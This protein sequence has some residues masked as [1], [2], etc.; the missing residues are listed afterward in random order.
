ME[1]APRLIILGLRFADAANLTQAFIL[2]TSNSRKDIKFPR[3]TAQTHIRTNI[4][5]RNYSTQKPLLSKAPTPRTPASKANALPKKPVKAVAAKPVVKYAPSQT[6]KPTAQRAAPEH[7]LVYHAGTGKIV[8]LGMLRTAT[9]FVAGAS[10]IIIAPAF[11]ADEFPSYLAPLIVIGGMLPLIFVAYTTAPFV[12]NIYLHLPVF[13]RKSREAA[14]EYVK[15]LPSTATLSIKT[16]KITTIPRTTEVRISDLVRDKS[17][18]RP[19]TFRN[20]YS[21]GYGTLKQFYAF[22]TSKNAR[23]T[24][25]FYPELWDH[26]FAQIQSQGAK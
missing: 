25:K 24:P 11:F 1:W 23:S 16:M 4:C 8:F 5:S 17:L 2:T 26:I 12:N 21:T 7:V 15:N 20:T 22:P 10:S 18:L 19:V 3:C 6:W 14:L 13:A 9:I